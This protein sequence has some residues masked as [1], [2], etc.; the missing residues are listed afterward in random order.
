MSVISLKIVRKRK[1]LLILGKV[2][3]IRNRI[4]THN[5]RYK[6][7][8]TRD[9]ILSG[10]E[11]FL[12]GLSL[13]FFISGVTVFPIFIIVG[14]VCS[15]L[16]FMLNRINTNLKTKD[17]INR[18][19]LMRKQYSDLVRNIENIL[20]RNGLNSEELTT[21]I[22][23]INDKI[24]LIEDNEIF[25]LEIQDRHVELDNS[26]SQIELIEGK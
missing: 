2:D 26:T 22:S 16:S 5:K 25:A 7:L 9:E 18:H 20:S 6:Q 24:N 21:L 15:G 14:G 11:S 1:K 13:A 3:F 17:K 19:L 23:D 4:K 10:L 8:K 12:S